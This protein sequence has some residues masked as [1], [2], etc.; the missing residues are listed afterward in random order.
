MQVRKVY[1]MGIS[2]SG[3]STLAQSLATRLNAPH[4]ELDAIHHQ[5][6]WSAI[7]D[8][9]FIAAL[10]LRL[11]A[12]SWV[13]DGNYSQVTGFILDRADAVILLDYPRPLVMWRVIL[14]TLRRGITRQELWNGNRESLRNLLS[15]NPETNIV[16][17][18]WTMHARRHQRNLEIEQVMSAAGREVHRF[19]HPRDTRA[20]LDS[21]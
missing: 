4:I 12:D 6:Q 17:W 16:L 8:A 7:S 14:R 18:A 3:K 1:I 21:I 19:E 20:W 10:E 11:A 15:R 9:D 5:P 2:G 13:V